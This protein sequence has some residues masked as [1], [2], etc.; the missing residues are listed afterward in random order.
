MQRLD[1]DVAM[2]REELARD[3]ERARDH[4]RWHILREIEHP[5]FLG[6]IA[7]RRRVVDHQRFVLDP[8]EQMRRAD[9]TE[10][11]RRVLPHQ[12][13]VDI[14]A[15][16]QDGE[17]AKAEMVARLRLDADF[18]RAGVQPSVLPGQRVGEIMVEPVA[19]RLRLQHQGKGRIPGDVDILQ[20]VHLHG[21]TKRHG[22]PRRRGSALCHPCQTSGKCRGQRPGTMNKASM[23]TSSLARM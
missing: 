21:D 8:F 2:L 18:V 22:A 10:V 15:K 23:R 4:R 16:V 17:S 13:H 9:I 14:A 6:R 3:A 5:Q 19:E 20:R 1:D 11:E 12:D 7:H